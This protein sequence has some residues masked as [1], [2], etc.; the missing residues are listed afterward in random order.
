MGSLRSSNTDGDVVLSA[1]DV[2]ELDRL[3]RLLR[4]TMK[5]E[6][7]EVVAEQPKQNPSA[8]CTEVSRVDLMARA[9]AVVLA[10]GE[11]AKFFSRSMFGEPAW[12]ML[13]ALYIAGDQAL[14][15]G[16]LV[17]MI[18]E[19][20]T[21]ALRWLDYLEEKRLIA[22]NPDPLDRR[23]VWVKLLER[24]RECLDGYFSCLSDEARAELK[25]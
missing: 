16:K 18:D 8:Q 6:N 7:R 15:V 20:K 13:L 23:F 17:S 25:I 4:S 22:R 1:S 2:R 3:L 14:S 5:G 21:T 19:P 9:H 11:R 24:G 12:D 10:R